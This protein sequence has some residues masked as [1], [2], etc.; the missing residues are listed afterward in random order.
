LKPNYFPA[1][2]EPSEFGNFNGR[3]VLTP[4]GSDV[5]EKKDIE[6]G[7][8]SVRVGQPDKTVD[9]YGFGK[10]FDV[11]PETLEERPDLTEYGICVRDLPESGK[12]HRTR[13]FFKQSAIGKPIEADGEITG[14]TYTVGSKPKKIRLIGRG[15]PPKIKKTTFKAKANSFMAFVVKEPVLCP[16]T[17]EPLLDDSGQPVT[18]E[19][20]VDT[21]E[22]P[23]KSPVT[24]ESGVW[25][26]VWQ[27]ATQ[28]KP[29]SFPAFFNPGGTGAPSTSPE[30]DVD[31]DG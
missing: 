26:A 28:K 5:P 21:K 22:L 16:D 20:F 30:P 11:T 17:N 6:I 2:N 3:W 23:A 4:K 19:K 14:Y 24:I 1:R 10:F 31:G 25:T 27:G 9:E 7:K 29:A 13:F 18:E 12:P 8:A 15:K